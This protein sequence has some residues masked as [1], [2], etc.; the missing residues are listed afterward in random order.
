MRRPPAR[1]TVSPKSN[2]NIRSS[3]LTRSGGRT[4]KNGRNLSEESIKKSLK[5]TWGR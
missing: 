5:I 3:T 1:E 2:R 4:R